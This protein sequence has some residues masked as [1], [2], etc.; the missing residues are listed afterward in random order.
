MDWLTNYIAHC[1]SLVMH[2]TLIEFKIGCINGFI[3]GFIIFE[4]LSHLVNFTRS[5][6]YYK[7][8]PKLIHVVQS[9]SFGPKEPVESSWAGWNILGKLS[10]Y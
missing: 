1:A 6:P 7:D 9:H 2:R 5:K 8:T 10:P 3:N 4:K